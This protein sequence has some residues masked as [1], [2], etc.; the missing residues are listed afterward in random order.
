[1]PKIH[2]LQTPNVPENT[3]YIYLS[4]NPYGPTLT[5]SIEVTLLGMQLE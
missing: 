3:P 2:Q 4:A 5:M 1:M